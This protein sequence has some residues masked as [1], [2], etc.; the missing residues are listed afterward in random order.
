MFTARDL[1]ANWVEKN[2]LASLSRWTLSMANTA[3]PVRLLQLSG[4]IINCKAVLVWKTTSEESS[5][6]F[7]IEHSRDGVLFKKVGKVAAASNSSTLK[8]YD[9]TVGVDEGQH[10]FRLRIV[11]RNGS[12]KISTVILLWNNCDNDGYVIYPNPV[13]NMLWIKGLPAGQR[14]VLSNGNGQIVRVWQVA[15]PGSGFDIATLA[16]GMYSIQ[17]FQGPVQVRKGSLVKQ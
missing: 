3:L 8:R 2:N 15:S 16:K 17:I 12:F 9:F 10:W 11:D 4:S 1:T 6:R 14:V 5:S 13:K 7:E